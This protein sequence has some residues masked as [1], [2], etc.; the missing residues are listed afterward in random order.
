MDLGKASLR[1]SFQRAI[2]LM[3]SPPYFAERNCSSGEFQCRNSG[4]CIPSTFICDAQSD[5]GDS[6]DETPLLCSKYCYN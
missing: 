1:L 3:T 2:K 5:C 4:L 6:S